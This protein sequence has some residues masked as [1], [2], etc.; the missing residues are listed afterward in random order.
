MCG[1]HLR[2]QRYLVSG[3]ATCMAGFV[4]PFGSTNDDHF[5][6]Y[7]EYIPAHLPEAGHFLQDHD[8]LEGLDHVEFH[9]HT[10]ELFEER[11]VYDMTF[12][13]NLARL[14]LDTRHPDAGFRYAREIDDPVT[15]RA[16]FTPTTPFCPQANTL[17]IGSFRAWNGLADR[18]EY[19]LVRVRI[20]PMH[21]QQTGINERLKTLESRFQDTGEITED[22]EGD[23]LSVG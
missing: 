11:T 14:N 16:V 3:V 22:G 2:A 12:G 10:R 17:A 18:H 6:D 5:D 13:Y 8:I 23:E 7:D 21:H 19:E 9:R 1:E 4:S 15:L 20:A